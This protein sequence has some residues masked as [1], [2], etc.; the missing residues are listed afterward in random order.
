MVKYEAETRIHLVLEMKKERE[1]AEKHQE[2]DSDD[3]FE[4]ENGLQD[5]SFEVG[6]GFVR[7]E[8]EIEPEQEKQIPIP[9]RE[10]TLQ[11]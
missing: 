1:D 10:E 9:R 7:E 11:K 5:V 8:V 6:R 4:P 2:G 3:N